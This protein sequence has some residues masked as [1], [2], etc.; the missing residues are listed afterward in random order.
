[1]TIETI[2]MVPKTGK[3]LGNYCISGMI[4]RQMKLMNIQIGMQ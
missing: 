4:S 2:K 3:M 1:M